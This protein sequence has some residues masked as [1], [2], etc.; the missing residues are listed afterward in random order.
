MAGPGTLGPGRRSA[1]L[2]VP[3]RA[4]LRTRPLGAC[5]GRAPPAKRAEVCKLRLVA[6]LSYA[7]IAQRLGICEKTVETQLARGLKF[8]RDRLHDAR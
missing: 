2:P 4:Q 7:Q 8:L 3:R 1:E 6:E 5:C